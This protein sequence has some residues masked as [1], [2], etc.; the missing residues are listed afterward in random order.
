MR[1][2]KK[3][4]A[5]NRRTDPLDATL[6]ILDVIVSKVEIAVVCTPAAV[7]NE[8]L[9]TGA[10]FRIEP[11]L[12]G[13]ICTGVDRRDR[14]QVVSAVEA[15]GSADFSRAERRA[16]GERSV[17]GA[18]HI[19]GVIFRP[20]PTDQS[21]K[22]RRCGV[23]GETKDLLD[24]GGSIRESN[25]ETIA[26]RGRRSSTEQASRAERETRRQES[27]RDGIGGPAGSAQCGDSFR[28]S[29]PDIPI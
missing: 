28:V 27:T 17:V 9:I 8:M 16:V 15:E 22:R 1:P 24:E 4:N 6:P 13:V 12:N 26:S 18:N 25:D 21:R 19:V 23:D 3:W 10:P 2:G 20:P 14:D 5:G 29:L 7:G 11:E